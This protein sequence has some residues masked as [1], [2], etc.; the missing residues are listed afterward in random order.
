[1]ASFLDINVTVVDR[2][3]IDFW[4]CSEARNVGSAWLRVVLQQATTINQIPCEPV[5]AENYAIL[6][7]NDA[8]SVVSV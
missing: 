8:Q 6:L 5:P 3:E 4:G 7:I 1:M 2:A